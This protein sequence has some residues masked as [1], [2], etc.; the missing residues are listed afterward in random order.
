M[1]AQD[2]EGDADK[3]WRS[4]LV[5]NKSPAAKLKERR[6]A[7]SKLMALKAGHIGAGDDA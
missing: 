3:E 7:S 4:T 5:T 2:L 1:H 6:K